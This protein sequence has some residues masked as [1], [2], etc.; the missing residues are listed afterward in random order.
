MLRITSITAD[1]AGRRLVLE[2][3][4]T[5][6]WVAELGSLLRLSKPPHRVRLDL[7][8]VHFVDDQG[9]V[10]LRRLLSEGAVVDAASP[11]VQELL[12]LRKPC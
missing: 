12:N 5:G 3:A 1:N 8:H 2:G 7:S 4:L 6:A 9:R 11:F 10:L